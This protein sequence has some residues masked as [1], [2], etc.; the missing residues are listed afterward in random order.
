MGKPNLTIKLFNK[1][2]TL[3]V[4]YVWPHPNGLENIECHEMSD[5]RMA[6]FRRS[7]SNPNDI[8]LYLIPLRDDFLFDHNAP[9][10]GHAGWDVIERERRKIQKESTETPH[11]QTEE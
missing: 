1:H 3:Q 9:T 6:W 4:L 5:G 7:I 8:K 2:T 11:E 10:D